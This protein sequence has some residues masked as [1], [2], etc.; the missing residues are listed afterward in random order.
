MLHAPSNAGNPETCGDVTC[1][2]AYSIRARQRSGTAKKSDCSTGRSSYAGVP[3]SQ[4]TKS[5]RADISG[6]V[7]IDED[8]YD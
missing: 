2:K 6:T 7:A 5:V 4:S 1:S 3:R 8:H